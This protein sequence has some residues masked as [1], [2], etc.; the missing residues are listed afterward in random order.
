M[1][2][3]ILAAFTAVEE[4]VEDYK[5]D[6]NNNDND[7]NNDDEGEGKGKE[8]EEQNNLLEMEKAYQETLKLPLA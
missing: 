7:E 1:V 4:A 6:H 3:E 8:E 5:D 2:S